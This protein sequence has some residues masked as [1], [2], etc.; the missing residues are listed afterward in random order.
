MLFKDILKA[1]MSRLAMSEYFEKWYSSKIESLPAIYRE[2]SLGRE[3]AIKRLKFC[4]KHG[5]FLTGRAGCGKTTIA[6][7]I[8][9]IIWEEKIDGKFIEYQDWMLALSSG[10][11]KNVDSSVTKV[12]TF[13]GLL[14]LDD[15]AF[16]KPSDFV[17]KVTYIIINHRVSNNLP[18]VLT[19]NLF[20]E[21][22]GTL[23]DPRLVSRIESHCEKVQ[24][25]KKDYRIMG[26]DDDE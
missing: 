24:P 17:Q 8:L 25:S 19:S 26:G 1:Y 11:R 4:N 6:T 23:Y 16:E 22:I 7:Q 9:R 2:G 3:K 15:I 13:P 10:E 5:I 12:K 20:L 14:V 21:E 18:L